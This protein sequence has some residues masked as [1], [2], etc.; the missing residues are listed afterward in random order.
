M[1]KRQVLLSVGAMNAYFA[2]GARLGAALARDGSL[3]LWMARGGTTGAVPR[4][5]LGVVT[6]GALASLSVIAVSGVTLE[7]PLLMITGAFTLVYVVGTASALRLLPRGTWVHRGAVL[8]FASTVALLFMTGTQMAGPALIG[9]GA[10]I[11]TWSRR[12]RR[13]VAAAPA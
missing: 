13:P 10:L 9:V 1:Y 4:R 3:P 12:E 6:L 5:S 8:S 7:A 2:G 11:W